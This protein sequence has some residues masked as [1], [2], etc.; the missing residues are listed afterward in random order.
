MDKLNE[1]QKGICIYCDKSCYHDSM[2][3]I[4]CVVV[5]KQIIVRYTDYFKQKE[6]EEH[7]KQV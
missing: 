2:L 1:P 3:H 7:E 5:G 4:E 6:E